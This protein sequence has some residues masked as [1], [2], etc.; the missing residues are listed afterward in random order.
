MPGF[1]RR[2]AGCGHGRARRPRRRRRSARPGQDRRAPL[3]PPAVGPRAARRNSSRLPHRRCDFAA[4]TW[5]CLFAGDLNERSQRDPENECQDGATEG[6]QGVFLPRRGCAVRRL[7]PSTATG[8]APRLIGTR[9]ARGFADGIASVLLASY[10]SRLGFSPLQIGAIA[11]ATLFGSALLLLLVGLLGH[12]FPR[13]KVLLASAALMCL[14]GIAFYLATDFWALLAVAFVGP[15]NP[16]SGDVTLFL[17]TE[18]AVLAEA[19]AAK[20]RTTLFAWYNLAG[21]FAGALGSLAAGA[22]DA[23]ARAANLDVALAE[24]LGFLAYAALGA[25]SALFY[26]R[27]SAAVEPPPAPNAAPLAKSRNVVL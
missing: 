26:F 21:A 2:R 11:T 10:L 22:P 18:Q 3:H 19:A 25:A 4:K 24:R 8:D 14:T 5:A 1:R 6:S 13:R 16:S 17:P 12:R 23:L 27:L 15:L 7:L 9:A 20:D